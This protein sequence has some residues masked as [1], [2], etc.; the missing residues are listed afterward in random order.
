MRKLKILFMGTPDFAV[1]SLKALVESGHNIVGV[2]TAPDKPAGRGRKLKSSAV[3]QY[4]QSQDLKILQPTNLKSDEFQNELKECDPN[5][6]VV[7]AFRMLPKM[8]WE[9]PSFGTFNLHASLLPH[10]RGAAPI[11]WA[12][13]N[14]EKET[15]VTTFFIDEDIDTGNII[16]SENVEILPKD[17]VER[18]HDK[19]MNVGAEL[20]VKTVEAIQNQEISPKSQKAESE[21]KGAPKLDKTNTKINWNQDAENIHNFIRGL[22]P[23]PVAWTELNMNNEVLKLKIYKVQHQIEKHN[24]PIG[25]TF[26][27]DKSIKVAVR[28]GFI[29]IKELQFPGKKRMSTA[30]LLNGMGWDNSFYF[31]S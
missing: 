24:R 10:Y 13:I 7:V 30:S 11:N 20:V 31:L 17:D 2:V 16:D 9:Y 18:L 28:N 19:L 27:E 3:K 5:L 6:I 25:S 15:G 12:I 8:V 23:F 22:S 21:L 4:A 26:I 29:L 1:G 14:G